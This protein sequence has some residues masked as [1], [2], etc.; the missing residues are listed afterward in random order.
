VHQ[1]VLQGLAALGAAAAVVSPAWA[2]A[3]EA[4][5]FVRLR[6]LAPT[7]VQ[8]MRYAGPHNF[9]GHP[10][11]GYGA[12]ECI[13]TRAA[14]SALARVQATLR[15]HG[16]GLIVWDCY[17]PVRAVRQFVRWTMDPDTRMRAEFYPAVEKS[18]IIPQGYVA[19]RSAHS[20][21]ST[22]DLGLRRLDAAL[23]RP[24]EQTDPLV[25]CTEPKGVRFEDGAVDL[26]PG[27][28]CFDARAHFD[29]ETVSAPARANRALLRDAM[30]RQGFVPY[31][32]EWWHFTLGREPFPRLT[33]DFPIRPRAAPQ[34]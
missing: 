8:D 14:A 31:A 20:R 25:A 16:Y 10:I 18:E 15:P 17:R 23:P 19:A 24:W 29:A 11:D 5:R 7:I 22:V 27:F 30:V 13:L 9:V 32:E 26:G 34:P 2:A 28:D 3:P 33:F 4:G 6:D 21:G 12:P 1:I